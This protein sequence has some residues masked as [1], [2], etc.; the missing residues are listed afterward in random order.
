MTEIE[1]SISNF[2]WNWLQYIPLQLLNIAFP[3]NWKPISHL[4]DYSEKLYYTDITWFHSNSKNIAYGTNFRID[5]LAEG[6]MIAR[7]G[8][9]DSK[10]KCFIG[11]L[12]EKTFITLICF[13]AWLPFLLYCSN[14][15]NESLLF[16]DKIFYENISLLSFILQSFLNSGDRQYWITLV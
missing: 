3:N 12:L 8:V 16:H 7:T 4:C 2:I 9:G 11:C 14:Y 6:L 13:R 10:T 1:E 15:R 5:S